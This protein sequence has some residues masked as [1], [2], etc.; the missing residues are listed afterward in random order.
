MLAV[1]HAVHDYLAWSETWI[2]RQIVGPR[3][4]D[5]TVVAV[6]ASAEAERRFPVAR[7]LV[8][9]RR[10]PLLLRPLLDLGVAPRR[11]TGRLAVEALAPYRS[12]LIHAH[13]GHVAWR[14]LTAAS[15]LGIPLVTSFYGYDMSELVERSPVWRE[16]YRELFAKG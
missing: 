7:L 13:F 5:P 11:L 6:R 8:L 4:V 15:R 3:D 1:A 9:A 14:F 10:A 12:Q 2:H 16:R